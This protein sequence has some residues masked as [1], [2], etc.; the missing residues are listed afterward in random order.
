MYALPE[1][2][3]SAKETKIA[4]CSAISTHRGLGEALFHIENVLH[5]G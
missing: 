3:A 1:C 5:G 4:K 2:P